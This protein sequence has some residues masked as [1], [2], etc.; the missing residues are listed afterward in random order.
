MDWLDE[1]TP[2]HLITLTRITEYRKKQEEG[3]SFEDSLRDFEE[4]G[5]LAGGIAERTAQK[6]AKKLKGDKDWNIFEKQPN[7][8]NRAKPQLDERHKVRLLEF[9]DNW[10]QA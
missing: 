6:W 8:A 10:P 9:Y 1:G 3:T 4:S 7:S 2:F 5:R